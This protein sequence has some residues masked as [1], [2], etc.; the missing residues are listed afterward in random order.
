MQVDAKGRIPE[1]HPSCMQLR[2][3]LSRLSATMDG[4][5]EG[6]SSAELAQ[7]SNLISS[8]LQQLRNSWINRYANPARRAAAVADPRQP[9][10]IGASGGKRGNKEK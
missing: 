4:L 5:A 8:E 1:G 10:L 6:H 3:D 9:R 7:L 2:R